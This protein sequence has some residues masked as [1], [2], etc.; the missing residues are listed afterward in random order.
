MKESEDIYLKAVLVIIG[1]AYVGVLLL[2]AL[3]VEYYQLMGYQPNMAPQIAYYFSPVLLIFVLVA[4]IPLEGIFRKFLNTPK[5]K[6]DAFLIGLV[7]STILIW[8][9]FPDHW[10]IF[11]IVNPITIR[12]IMGLTNKDRLRER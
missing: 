6:T 3:R 11:I 9:A 5:T 8:W 1:G 12:V 4:A 7:Y 2:V 10:Y